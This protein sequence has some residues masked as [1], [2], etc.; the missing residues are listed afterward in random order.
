VFGALGAVWFGAF[1]APL[2]F[3]LCAVGWG[4][5]GVGSYLAAWWAGA[6][7]DEPT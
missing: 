7:A 6:G 4:V 1:A 3:L 2:V 5:A